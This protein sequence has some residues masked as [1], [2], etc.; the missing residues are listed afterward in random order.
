M[1]WATILTEELIMVKGKEEVTEFRVSSLGPTS[2]PNWRSLS[3][4]GELIHDR[5]PSAATQGSES[6]T[7]QSRAS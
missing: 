7:E 5:Q 2:P 3:V 4:P 6:G 1:T